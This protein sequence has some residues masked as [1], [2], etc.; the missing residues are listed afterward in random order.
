MRIGNRTKNTMAMVR[1][2]RDCNMFHIT[3]FLQC[4]RRLDFYYTY[5]MQ[6]Q[7]DYGKEM[8]HTELRLVKSFLIRI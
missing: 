7:V 5:G 8:G 3:F 1:E 6:L 2:I 4:C